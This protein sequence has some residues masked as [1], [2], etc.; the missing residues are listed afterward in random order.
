MAGPFVPTPIETFGGL[1]DAAERNDLPPYM[2]REALNCAWVPGSVAKRAGFSQWYESGHTP[3]ALFLWAAPPL[4][5]NPTGGVLLTVASNGV[6][7]PFDAAGTTI[8]GFDDANTSAGIGGVPTLL[9]YSDSLV[10]TMSDGSRGTGF[11]SLTK[12]MFGGLAGYPLAVRLYL[13]PPPLALTL[14]QVVGGGSLTAGA[15][16]VWGTFETYDGVMSPPT[17]PATISINSNDRID[18]GLGANPYAVFP[19]LEGVVALHLWMGPAGSTTD[20]YFVARVSVEDLVAT[21]YRVGLADG[22]LT[23]AEKLDSAFLKRTAAPIL[24]AA[25][26]GPYKGRVCYLGAPHRYYPGAGVTTRT[27]NNTFA[28]LGT[29]S[30]G[31]GTPAT[32]GLFQPRCYRITFDGA[33]AS[34]GK[35]LNLG[36]VVDDLAGR[37]DKKAATFTSARWG[38]RAMVRKSAGLT[39]GT[40]RFGAVG[41]IADWWSDVDVAS[42]GTDWTLL[43]APAVG[44]EWSNNTVLY[45][46]GRGPGVNGQ[47]L[48]V[49]LVEA[50]DPGSRWQDE[51]AWWSRPHKPRAVD[52]TWGPV[53]V[54]AGVQQKLRGGFALG[55]RFYYVLSDSIWVTQDDGN[56]PAQWPLE[57]IAEGVG[58]PSYNGIGDGTDWKVIAGPKGC[59]LFTGGPV[60]DDAD[61]AREIPGL[62]SRIA[63]GGYG[64]LVWVRVMPSLKQV[65]IGVPLDSA[66]VVS[67]VLVLDY[68]EG[69][70]SGLSAGGV[71]RRWSLWSVQ[72]GGPAIEFQDGA[73]DVRALLPLGTK[74]AYRNPAVHDDL[75]APFSFVWEGGPIGAPELGIGLFRKLLVSAEGSGVLTPSLVKESGIPAQLISTTLYTPRRG[76]FRFLFNVVDERVG[77]RFEQGAVAGSWVR[78]S[79]T[80]LWWMRH[81]LA[82]TRLQNP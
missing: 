65:W 68:T 28:Y 70:G 10:R 19:Q 14:T 74:V 25:V 13:E 15:H 59:F 5:A 23:T 75:T 20:G 69:F 36:Y 52:M 55:D 78:L 35:V 44:V 32:G 31:W 7:R 48:E 43:E 2:A 1:C 39:S 26:L 77:L 3:C 8:L 41:T 57:V 4:P 38:I 21:P 45:L 80:S 42:I 50:Y 29:S 82:R 64:Q 37:C 40:F 67:H 9:Q 17:P 62:W 73:G 72:P 6:V 51:T 46:E 24:P 22:V 53:T 76:D 54:G 18:I 60:S 61:L 81:P 16:T 11:A 34:R 58:T 47:Y 66:T 56:E 49:G 33:A 12:F 63:W 30:P 27:Q 71:G 79:R